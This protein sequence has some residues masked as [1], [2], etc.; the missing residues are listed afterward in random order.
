MQELGLRGWEIRGGVGVGA[1][2]ADGGAGGLE[3]GG[4]GGVDGV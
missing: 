3:E 2:D 1:E 4:D